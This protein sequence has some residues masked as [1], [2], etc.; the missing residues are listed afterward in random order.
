MLTQK[1]HELVSEGVIETS[2]VK[3]ALRVHVKHMNVDGTI[4][5]NDRAY[6]PTDK[7]ISNHAYMAK[8]KLE[9]SS[10]D[11]ENA[12]MKIEAWNKSNPQASF[13]F[14]HTK[15]IVVT[16]VINKFYQIKGPPH[17]ILF[18]TFIKRSGKRSY[19]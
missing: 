17:V 13:F 3:R 11:Q 1:I 10:L 16:A 12:C 4:D 9:L 2:E 5:P 14:R 15:K 8:R 19:W 7:D 18:S 6:N